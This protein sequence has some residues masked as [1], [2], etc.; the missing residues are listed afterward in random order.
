MRR[1][2][3][4]TLVELMI[5]IAIMAVLGAVGIPA[6]QSMI[7]DNRIVTTSNALLG[8]LQM[9][10]SEAASKRKN[11][12][13]CPSTDQQTCTANGNWHDGI[14][15]L[16]DTVLLR[17]IPAT[18]NGVQITS[19]LSELVYQGNG[20]TQQNNPQFRIFDDRDAAKPATGRNICINIIGQVTSLRGNQGC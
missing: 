16:N 8:A 14:I 20:R 4:F 10:R 17:V 9:A 15:V 6:F 12:R 18:R 19:T 11:I 7:L 5:A 2:K 3:G 1:T 13:V